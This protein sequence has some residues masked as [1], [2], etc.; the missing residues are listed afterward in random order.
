[1]Y[2]L[3]LAPVMVEFPIE[4]SYADNVHTVARTENAR[5]AYMTRMLTLLLLLT[6]I[7]SACGASTT[8][9]QEANPEEQQ[10][11]VTVFKPP[12]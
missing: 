3:R 5:R 11:V 1:M 4:S 8:P 10:N 12:T 9:A 7:L 2:D 6:L